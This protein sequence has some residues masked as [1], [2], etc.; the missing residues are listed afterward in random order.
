MVRVDVV[1]HKIARTTA[2]LNDAEAILRRPREELLANVKERDLATFYL[3]LAIQECIDLAAHWVTD[4]GWGT[5]DDAGSTFDVLADR[6]VIDRELAGRLR[7]AVGLRNRIAHGYAA[8]DHGR[9][10]SEFQEGVSYLRRF[11][12][13]V[14]SEAGLTPS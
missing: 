1:S 9:L 7:N 2:W 8:V 10:Q 14:A 13:Q 5:S 3:F 4:A 11:L 6:Q 12:D